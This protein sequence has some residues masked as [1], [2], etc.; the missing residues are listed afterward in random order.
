MYLFYL[1]CLAQLHNFRNTVGKE[2]YAY[3]V[4]GFGCSCF[5]DS[6]T[7]GVYVITDG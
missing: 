4:V 3:F 1:K 5:L 2:Y 6:I 7:F